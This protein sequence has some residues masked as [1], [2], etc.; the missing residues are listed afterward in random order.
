MKKVFGVWTALLVSGILWLAGCSRDKGS[1]GS[2]PLSPPTNTAAITSAVIS[3]DST[4][5]DTCT[6]E[7]KGGPTVCLDCEGKKSTQPSTVLTA[8]GTPKGG[9]YKWDVT[10]GKEKVTL[11]S[12]A[13][14]AFVKGKEPS[15]AELDVTVTVIYT[16]AGKS[17]TKS[18]KLT[19][20]KPTKLELIDEWLFI[21]KDGKVQEAKKNGVTQ[22]TIPPDV[23]QDLDPVLKQEGLAGKNIKDIVGVILI[24]YYKVL[25]QFGDLWKCDGMLTEVI[26]PPQGFKKGGTKVKQGIPEHPDRLFNLEEEKKFK[27]KTFVQLIKVSGCEVRY[28][29]F[30]FKKTNVVSKELT[31]EEYK[32]ELEELG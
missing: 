29:K 18:V 28:N 2:D 15:K 25:D 10:E 12:N 32:K 13:D 27:E 24:R 19:V 8:V 21:V 30:T 11:T 17:C 26:T 4:A 9:T 7:I 16:V 3:L 1:L 6:V 22:T 31:A 5:T 23:Q 14:K 20:V